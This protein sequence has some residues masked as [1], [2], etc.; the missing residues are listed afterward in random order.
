MTTLFN[1]R[2]VTAQLLL[3]IAGLGLAIPG[4][5]TAQELYRE[6][7]HYETLPA[8]VPTSSG[9]KIEV[10]EMFWYGCPHCFRLEPAVEKW[11][12][13][14][15]DN[16]EYVRVPGVGGRW[17]LGAQAFYTA[18]KLGMLEKIHT[19]MFDAIHV[20]KRPINNVEQLADFFADQGVDRQ[21]FEKALNSFEVKTNMQ[22]A[23]QLM[24]RY[25]VTGV[26]VLIVNGQYKTNS[27][28]VVDFLVNKESG[29][30]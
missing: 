21:A 18:E 23:K 15:P 28:D 1:R 27:F 29:S 30:S 19:A 20:E 7:V 11:L 6:G 10:V 2:A 25:R 17:D 9:D 3:L 5:V 22:R 8:K 26:P 12:E 13:T 14:K 24:Q 16:V 4:A